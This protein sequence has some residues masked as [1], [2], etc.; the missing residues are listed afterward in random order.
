[1]PMLRLFPSL[2]VL[3]PILSNGLPN[4]VTGH[5]VLNRKRQAYIT[6]NL[7]LLKTNSTKATR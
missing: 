4:T 3:L 1:M 7:L 2:L 6:S 5:G